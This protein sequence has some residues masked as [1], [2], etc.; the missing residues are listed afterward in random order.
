MR[1]RAKRW[2]SSTG[3]RIREHVEHLLEQMAVRDVDAVRRDRAGGAAVAHVEG[4]LQNRRDARR[5]PRSGTIALQQAAPPE[6]MPQTGLMEGLNELAIRRPAVAFEAARKVLPEHRR[7]VAKAAAGAN[8]IDGRRGGRKHPQ[9]V[10]EPADLPARFIGHDDRTR[11]HGFAQG[12]VG[13]LTVRCGVVE[14]THQ[15]TGR[16]G[17]RSVCGTAPPSCRT[18]GRIVC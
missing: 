15:R 7:G 18:T 10:Q 4:V 14:G 3:P 5:K 6:E 9:P 2:I 16:H 1:C 11:A 12:R 17:A 8:P 13:R